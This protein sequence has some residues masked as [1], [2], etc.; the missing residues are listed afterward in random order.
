MS[1]IIQ[2][3]IKQRFHVLPNNILSVRDTDTGVNIH[4][5]SRLEAVDLCELLNK[6]YEEKLYAEGKALT[7]IAEN[8]KLVGVI[9]EEHY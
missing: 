8:N 2:S 1:I 3:D 7:A 5:G 9:T 4:L 6:L